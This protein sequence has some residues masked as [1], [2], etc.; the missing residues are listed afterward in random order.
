MVSGKEADP[1]D[2]KGSSM[3]GGTPRNHQRR[4]CSLSRPIC[5]LGLEKY[6]NR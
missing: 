2:V 1:T 4:T 6:N 5:P 3:D